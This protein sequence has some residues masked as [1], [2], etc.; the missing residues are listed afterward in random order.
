MPVM[1]GVEA[2]RVIRREAAASQRR[3]PVAIAVTAN[4]MTDQI[5][6]YRAAGFHDTLPKPVRFQQLEKMLSRALAP[7]Q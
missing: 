6:L 1:D 7:D 5:A 2:L 3:C 4:V